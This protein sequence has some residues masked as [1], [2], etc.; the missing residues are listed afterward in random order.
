[1]CERGGGERG[2]PLGNLTSQF[3]ANVY[4]NQLDQF[5]KHQLKAKYYIRY[6]DDFVILHKHKKTLEIYKERINKFLKNRLLIELHPGKSKI[7][8][9]KKGIN[10]LGFRIFNHHKL[11]RK[12]NLRK[13][14]KTLESYK[15]IYTE[16][17][18]TYD[19]I[20]EYLQGW[21]AY[22]KQANT[23]KLRNKLLAAIEQEFPNEVAALE[24]NKLLKMYQANKAINKR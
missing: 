19:Q 10:F 18:I 17:K 24:I 15:Q 4:L 20:Y 12:T 22:A 16:G 21:L 9:L 2:L 14:K 5:V 3:F 7:M 11:L 8:P 23:Y 13:I 1:L 6:V